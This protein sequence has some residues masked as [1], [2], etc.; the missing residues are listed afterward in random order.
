VL[1]PHPPKSNRITA[2]P[3]AAKQSAMV[4]NLSLSLELKRPWQVIT[5]GGFA[6][7]GKWTS[8][9]IDL[10]ST[11]SRNGSSISM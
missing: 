9:Q 11:F 3:L 2:I 8:P 4:V 5:Q 1:S 6:A 7:D 10:F